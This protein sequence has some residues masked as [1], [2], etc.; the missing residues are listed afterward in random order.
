MLVGWSA[1]KPKPRLEHHGKEFSGAQK[2]SPKAHDFF[3]R[4]E[5][6]DHILGLHFRRGT[7]TYKG[8]E[9]DSGSLQMGGTES[10]RP[11]HV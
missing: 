6:E 2:A 4:A 5:M 10:G 8:L 9:H 11:V 7:E 3:V 1:D